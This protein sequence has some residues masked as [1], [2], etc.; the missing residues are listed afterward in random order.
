VAWDAV[1]PVALAIAVMGLLLLWRHA[2]NIQ[3]LIA[4]KE[5]KIGAKKK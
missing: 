1:A 3:R 4:G 5:T 2:E